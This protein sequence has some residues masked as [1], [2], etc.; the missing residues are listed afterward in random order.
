MIREVLE[1]VMLFI[2]LQIYFCVIIHLNWNQKRC[3]DLIKNNTTLIV[4]RFLT[5]LSYLSSVAEA[6]V[7]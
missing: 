7:L 5:A 4:S 2:C 1:C 3:S 6:L